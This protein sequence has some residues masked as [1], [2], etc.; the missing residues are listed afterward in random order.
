MLYVNNLDVRQS[1][2]ANDSASIAKRAKDFAIAK[3]YAS[4]KAYGSNSFFQSY[5]NI[6]YHQQDFCALLIYSLG[7]IFF[8]INAIPTSV[9]KINMKLGCTAGDRNAV[10]RHT[11]ILK[12][13]RGSEHKLF[14]L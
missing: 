7:L 8:T 1:R 2:Q 14:N 10:W 5:I 4:R 6:L 13:Q 11:A 12:L 3:S 9:M